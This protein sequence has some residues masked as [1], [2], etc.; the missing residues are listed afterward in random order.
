MQV[1]PESPSNVLSRY[2]NFK[3]TFSNRNPRPRLPETLT[4]KR[5]T[6]REVVP[7][8][9]HVQFPLFLIHLRCLLRYLSNSL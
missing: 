9:R 8:H 1:H 3:P 2:S 7:S 6:S 5:C 4:R